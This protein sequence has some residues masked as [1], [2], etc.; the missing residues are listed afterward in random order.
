MGRSDGATEGRSDEGLELWGLAVVAGHIPPDEDRGELP[1]VERST[2]GLVRRLIADVVKREYVSKP[3]W[4]DDAP[5]REYTLG[6]LLDRVAGDLAEDQ[7]EVL[8]EMFSRLRP[9]TESEGQS[10][11]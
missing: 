8:R 2:L 5:P 4:Q 7:Q 11:N 1:N 9:S 6:E 10:D 3:T